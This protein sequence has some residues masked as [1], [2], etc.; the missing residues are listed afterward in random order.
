MKGLTES[1]KV[2]DLIKNN[3]R[4][5]RGYYVPFVIYKD[6]FKINDEEKRQICLT[7]RRCSIC[8]QT[9]DWSETWYVAG[10]GSLFHFNGAVVDTAVHHECGK[11]ALQVCPYLAYNMYN[12]KLNVEKLQ[13]KHKNLILIDP[14]VELDRVPLFGFVNCD[15]RAISS[16]GHLILEK[17]YKKV[18]FWNDGKRLHPKIG[19][20]IVENYLLTKYN[21]KPEY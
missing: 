3:C 1:I 5:L 8:G 7:E 11:Y 21:V 18:E 20:E 15:Y 17:P 6:N 19:M 14:T 13:A 16:I 9:M 4:Q 2:P 10:P 12:K